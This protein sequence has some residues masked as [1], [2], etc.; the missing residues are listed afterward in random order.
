MVRFNMSRIAVSQFAILSESL[1]QGEM[2]MLTEI[3][4]QYSSESRQIACEAGFRFTHEDNTIL[5][6]KVLCEFRIHESDWA[7]FVR[8]DGVGIPKSVL[9][10]LA[11]QLACEKVTEQQVGTSRGILFCKTEGTA[12]NSLMIPPLNVARMMEDEAAVVK[13]K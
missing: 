13:S 2:N 5:V 11:V 10:I 9:E 12:F 7:G 3:S 8:K 4:F 6:L 1:P